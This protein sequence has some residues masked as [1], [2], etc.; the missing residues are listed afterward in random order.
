[1]YSNGKQLRII[2]NYAYNK[3]KLNK[4]LFIHCLPSRSDP[5]A[6]SKKQLKLSLSLTDCFI[7]VS[8]RDCI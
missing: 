8:I 1:M 7:E 6:T 5:V 2:N 4:S 3:A